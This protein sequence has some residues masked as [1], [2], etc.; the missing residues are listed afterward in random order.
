M[1]TLFKAI[2]SVLALTLSV[3]AQTRWQTTHQGS[4]SGNC[5]LSSSKL[6][7][8]LHPH[9]ADVIEEAEITTL[10]SV[11]SGDPKT[12]EITGT[13]TL[14]QGSAIRSM[15]LWNGNTILKAKLLLRA[16]ADSAYEDVVERD[17]IQ[18][19]SRDPAIIHY[20]GNDQYQFKIYPVDINQSRKIRILYTV[21]LQIE[22]GQPKFQINTAFTNNISEF[23][24]QIPFEVF[25]SDSSVS[26]CILQHGSVRKSVVYNA[27]Y[28][29]PITDFRGQYYDHSTNTYRLNG[30]ILSPVL[31][32]K[33]FWIQSKI[34]TG[35]TK[36]NYYSIIAT[37]PDTL[38]KMI[39]EKAYQGKSLNFEA[40]ITIGDKS[41]I[42]STQ[43][44]STICTF[45]K[46]DA[47]WDSIITWNCYEN[48]SG[49]RLFTYDQKFGQ[50]VDSACCPTL[51]LLWASRYSLKEKKTPLGGLYGF[52]DSKMSLLA[53]EDDTLSKA[54]YPTYQN[55]GIPLLN[56]NEIV[57]NPSKRPTAP[58]ESI[59][60]EI[61]TAVKNKHAIL[62]QF[63]MTIV[64]NMLKIQ[65]EKTFSGVFSVV[66]VDARGRTVQKFDNI[67]MKNLSAELKLKQGLKGTFFVR[68]VT[69]KDRISKQLILN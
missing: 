15:L 24:S 49:L 3:N 16:D 66:L 38:N 30:V 42:S 9:Y 41:Y 69:G 50:T 62:P 65:F 6:S 5:Q 53:L 48:A 18:F 23:P 10:G 7:V 59:I 22:N 44:N 17:K 45:I 31:K 33:S 36:G 27:T 47:V 28:N 43:K 21:P 20:L 1:K 4:S 63:N 67:Q 34:D 60:F 57:I 58:Q 56:A 46:T 8:T 68:I 32:E 40:K 54:L 2:V 35:V 52:V 64:N 55:Q 51:P 14:S 25:Q 12:L 11:W 13:F 39:E 29:I 26:N 37:Q 19:V 61:G